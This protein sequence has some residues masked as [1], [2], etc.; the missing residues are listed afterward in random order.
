MYID[1][2]KITGMVS[3]ADRASLSAGMTIKEIRTVEEKP[4][5]LH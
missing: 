1:G 2:V 3:F 4:D 5:V